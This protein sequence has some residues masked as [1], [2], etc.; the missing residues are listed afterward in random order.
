MDEILGA[1][2]AMIAE[3]LFEAFYAIIIESLIALLLRGVRSVFSEFSTINLLIAGTGSGILGLAAGALSLP[4]FPHPMFHPSRIHGMSLLISPVLTGLFM[5]WVG[6]A[7][8]KRGQ[9]PV[10]IESFS[11]GFA[12]ALGM[13]FVRYI[14]RP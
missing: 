4:I 6:T 9:R 1:L 14:C 5:W 10:Q 12:F 13:A 2:F 11:C 3:V 8:R 7:L